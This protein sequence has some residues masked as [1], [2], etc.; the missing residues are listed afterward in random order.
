M[1]SKRFM[2]LLA[3]VCGLIV[4]VQAQTKI[5]SDTDDGRDADR[6]AIRAHIGSIFQA[7]IDGDIDTIRATHAEDWRGF[8]EGSRT[9]I[10]GIDEYMRA[11]GIPWPRPAGAPAA[12]PTS[13][14]G[15]VG[16]QVRDFDVHFYGP[17]LAV[18]CFLGEFERKS[19]TSTVT[20]NRLR[21]MDVYAKRNGSWIQ[22]ASNTVTDPAYQTERTTTP[23]PSVPPQMRQQIL[24]A[25]E[26]VWKAYFANDQATLEKL[27]PAEAIA[28][29]EGAETWGDRAAILAGAKSF[30]ES[31]GK[32]VKLEFPKTELQVY[33]N[34]VIVYTTY[35]YEIET[36]GIHQTRAGRGTEMFVRRGGIFVNVGWH[37]D[38]VHSIG[39]APLQA[40]H[41]RRRRGD[42]STDRSGLH[43]EFAPIANARSDG[44]RGHPPGLARACLA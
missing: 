34:V 38:G 33:G 44:R 40:A 1:S 9:P 41:E 8:L 18:A 32:L 13:S 26:A 21:I 28:V 23:L 5:A 6:A 10:R 16:Y 36:K 14:P 20:L 7:F 22:V 4:A 11:N 12:K 29:N 15:E 2:S 27:I 35:S 37:L 31:G 3:V 17:E 24:D 30:A 42:R 43:Q 25:R 19:G 39:A